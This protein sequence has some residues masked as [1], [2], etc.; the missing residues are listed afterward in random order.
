MS[1]KHLALNGFDMYTQG[2]PFQLVEHQTTERTGP[3]GAIRKSDNIVHAF[4]D[5]AGRFRIESGF[6]KNGVFEV[7]NIILF[8]PVALTSVTFAPH[9]TIARLTQVEP[10][11]LPTADDERK[12][13]EQAARSAAY[14]RAHPEDFS[15]EA[16][17]TRTI[18]GEQA[19]GTRKK[20]LFVALDGVTRFP[21]VTEAWTSPDLKI[22]LL[23]IADDPAIGKITTEVT[24]LKRTEPGPE[25]FKV[26]A[27]LTIEVQMRH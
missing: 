18:A 11:Q 22:D 17:G 13:A 24:E 25:L 26:P 16:L 2:E 21:R 3:D 5:A 10:R 19:V 14:D 8:D 1:G 15:E 23:K 27:G 20:Q 9:G 7:R 6:I 4:R 12:A